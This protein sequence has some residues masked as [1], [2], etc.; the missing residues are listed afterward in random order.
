MKTLMLRKLNLRTATNGVATLG[1]L[2][3]L[4]N[5]SHADTL[6]FAFHGKDT[7]AAAM[8]ELDATFQ[9]SGEKQGT[10]IN[11]DAVQI[12]VI[13]GSST[14]TNLFAALG[15][16]QLKPG[17]KK[18]LF[19]V[20]GVTTQP[21]TFTII[22]GRDT[23]QPGN[24]WKLD[25]N[26]KTASLRTHGES[27]DVVFKGSLAPKSDVA[28]AE[29]AKTMYIVGGIIALATLGTGI[30]FLESNRKRKERRR[31]RRRSLLVNDTDP[32]TTDGT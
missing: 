24:V 1:I 9:L 18:I 25:I 12:V 23:N 7:S 22:N 19:P 10:T 17:S 5:V 11:V 8:G 16:Y 2:M 4:T 30:Y 6:Q 26:G 3:A 21:T 13:D 27:M 20:S 31:K 28:E 32:Q 14:A 29:G 15:M